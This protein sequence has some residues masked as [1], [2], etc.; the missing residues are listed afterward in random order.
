MGGAVATS[1]AA[2]R[3]GRVGQNFH[4]Q[5]FTSLCHALLW[6]AVQQGILHLV[7]GEGN[8]AIAQGL[9]HCAQTFLLRPSQVKRK[10]AVS[11]TTVCKRMSCHK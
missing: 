3:E 10:Y 6:R 1:E 9:V 4:T 8:A 11:L 2:L 7:R 5:L